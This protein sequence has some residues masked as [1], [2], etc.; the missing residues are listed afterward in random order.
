M[1]RDVLLRHRVYV[2]IRAN[3]PEIAERKKGAKD[4]ASIC[5]LA[6]LSMP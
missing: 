6:V 3:C 2:P 4:Y 1:L 5:A